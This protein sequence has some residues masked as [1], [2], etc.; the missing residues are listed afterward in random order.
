M[1][2]CSYGGIT[3]PARF[4]HPSIIIISIII[5]ILVWSLSG[6]SIKPL[7]KLADLSGWRRCPQ[8]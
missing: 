2:K 6:H 8:T 3:Q 1:E 5:I 4:S 7:P